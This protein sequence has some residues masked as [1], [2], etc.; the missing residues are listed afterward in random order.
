MDLRLAHYKTFL[1]VCETGSFSGAAQTLFMTQPAVSQMMS[2]MEQNFGLKLFNRVPKGVVLTEEGKI[3]REHT[4]A[5]LNL[6][7]QGE[8]KLS[9]AKDLSYGTLKIGVG[10]TLSKYFLLP[11]LERFHLQAP[12]IQLRII[13]RTSL[14]MVDMLKKGEI[15]I[16]LCNLPLYEKS[17]EAISC[18]QI[19][20]IFV[21]G[22]EMKKSLQM[23]LNLQELAQKPLILLEQKSNS[24]RYV[25]QYFSDRGILLMPEIELGSYDL[26]LEFAKINLGIACVIKEFTQDYLEKGLL[27]QV[28]LTEPLPSRNIGLCFLKQV[29]LSPASQE[30]LDM[31]KEGL[32]F[33]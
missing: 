9:D 26:L 22:R 32:K 4:K 13:N 16:A 6:L 20:D 18:K 10:D 14:E 8:K 33:S 5:A 28:D 7:A 27:F 31:M 21:C 2:Q 29:S 3:L 30:L 23:P 1:A 12:Q 15:D 11:Y 19:Q 24:R 25:T 17:I